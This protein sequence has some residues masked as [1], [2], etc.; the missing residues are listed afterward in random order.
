MRDEVDIRQGYERPR[1]IVKI[2]LSKTID[3]HQNCDKVINNTT[4]GRREPAKEP[5][6]DVDRAS[7]TQDE[8]NEN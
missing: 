5:A 8:K 7:G 6:G 3:K 2:N 1:P 4:A